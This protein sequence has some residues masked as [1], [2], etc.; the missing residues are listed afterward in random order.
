MGG[1]GPAKDSASRLAA[2]LGGSGATAVSGVK[3][4]ALAPKVARESTSPGSGQFASRR[5]LAGNLREVLND[6]A[7]RHADSTPNSAA[8]KA[9]SVHC[10]LPF[11]ITL[12]QR[13]LPG[14][15]LLQN[16]VGC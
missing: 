9:A 15:L 3:L 5:R 12:E 4:A 13:A 6:D 14:Q 8:L 2:R 1:Q 11:G 10:T 7:I 16:D